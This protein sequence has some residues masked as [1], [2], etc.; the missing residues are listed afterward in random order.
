MTDPTTLGLD[1]PVWTALNGAQRALALQEGDAARFSSA[2]TL[3]AGVRQHDATAH[4][5]LAHLLA[6]GETTGVLVDRADR[7][8]GPA[9]HV[10]DA[11]E[12]MQMVQPLPIVTAEEGTTAGDTAR[13]M[14]WVALGIEDA[15]EMETLA[16]LTRP[17]PFG[18]RTVELGGYVGVRV[19]GRLIAMAG[20]RLRLGS[21]V[22]ISAVC[23]HPD[24]AGRGLG[25]A[26]VRAVCAGIHRSGALPF[27]HVRVDNAGAIALYGRLGFVERRRL[28]Y[29]IVRSG[30]SRGRAL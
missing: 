26:L 28:R 2:H 19:G 21:H 5:A 4:D 18:A 29:V 3:L 22:E 30:G 17:G 11:I 23:T 13:G 15:R 6:D 9:L 24:H 27:L 1:N 12:V 7:L 16:A 14:E 20:H 25:G 8:L 10:L